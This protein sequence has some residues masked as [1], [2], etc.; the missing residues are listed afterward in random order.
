MLRRNAPRRRRR[1]MRRL[2][3]VD[4]IVAGV[5]QRALEVEELQKEASAPTP[6]FV[7]P[8]AAELHK[9]AETCRSNAVTVSVNDVQAFAER[10]MR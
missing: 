4:A 10:L 8:L 9:L 6:T 3:R 1:K 2:P 7:V 5:T